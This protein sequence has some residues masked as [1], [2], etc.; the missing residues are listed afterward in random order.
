MNKNLDEVYIT[1]L[2]AKKKYTN[3]PKTKLKMKIGDH[4]IMEL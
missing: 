1:L 2:K 4:I 3:I